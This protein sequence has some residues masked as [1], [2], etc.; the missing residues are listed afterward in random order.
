MHDYVNNMDVMFFV[1][2]N[3]KQMLDKLGQITFEPFKEE[4]EEGM[5]TNVVV[6]KQVNAFNRIIHKK[7]QAHIFSKSWNKFPKGQ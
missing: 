7:F 6:E 1:A 4:Q 3:M 2:L 5:M